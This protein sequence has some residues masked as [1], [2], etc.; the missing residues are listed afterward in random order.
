MPILSIPP[1]VEHL[2]GKSS[3][4][5]K[6]IQGSDMLSAQSFRT[7]GREDVSAF[8]SVQTRLTG[9]ASC[10]YSGDAH[11]QINSTPQECAENT[12]SRNIRSGVHSG[13]HGCVHSCLRSH[14]HNERKQGSLMTPTQSLEIMSAAPSSQ[15]LQG[16]AKASSIYIYFFFKFF[17][18]GLLSF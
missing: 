6:S 14:S 1:H 4:H 8:Q 10:L 9:E 15:S 5:K 18:F 16:V 13:T 3:S 12:S 7:P 11:I 17:F 2:H